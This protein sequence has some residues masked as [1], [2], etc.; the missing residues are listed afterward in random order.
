MKDTHEVRVVRKLDPATKKS[1]CSL[2]WV[3][4]EYLTKDGK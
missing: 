4:N 2:K 3:S 1:I